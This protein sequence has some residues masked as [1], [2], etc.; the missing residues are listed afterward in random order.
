MSSGIQLTAIAASIAGALC[1]YLASPNQHILAKPWPV[2]LGGG[3]AF[4]L[5][6][7]G[8]LIWCRLLDPAAAFF[9]VLTMAMATLLA[10]PILSALVRARR[11]N[12]S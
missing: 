9:S 10:T 3:G 2:W 11:G 12:R 5:T 6:L 8:W 7:L 1:L 4:T